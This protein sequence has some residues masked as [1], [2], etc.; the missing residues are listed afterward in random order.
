VSKTWSGN[1]LGLFIVVLGCLAGYGA[2][3]ISF[4]WGIVIGVGVALFGATIINPAVVRQGSADF[5]N[6]A[7]GLVELFP[8]KIGRRDSDPTVIVA[9]P[10]DSEDKG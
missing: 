5:K 4:E 3:R 1:L 9:K 2:Y 8:V 6:S 7:T 10:S